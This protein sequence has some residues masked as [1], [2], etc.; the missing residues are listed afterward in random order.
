MKKL[1]LILL[2]L[3]SINVFSQWRS[4]FRLTNDPSNS[5]TSF[6]NAHCIAS[7]GKIVHVTW[8]DNRDGNYEIYYKRSTNGGINWGADT[9]LSYT[10]YVSYFPS[11]AV[12]GQFIYIVWEEVKN[13][14]VIMYTGSSNG[15]NNWSEPSTVS[16][17]TDSASS[18]SLS[19]CDKYLHLVWEDYSN[20][21]YEIYY[22]NSTDGGISWGSETRLTNNPADSYLPCISANGQF[23]HVVWSDLRTGYSTIYYKHSTNGGLSWSED[24]KL[25]NN[26]NSHS[27]T[28]SISMY[29]NLT[30]VVWY[31]NRD[32][33]YEI[34][35]TQSTNGGTN[36]SADTRLTNNSAISRYPSVAI[37]GQTV[38]VVWEDYRDAGGYS[39]IFYKSST[40][41]GLNW[42]DELRLVN[43][44]IPYTGS[45]HPSISASHDS[46]YVI[47][48]DN[49]DGNY[50]VYF[51]YNPDVSIAVQNISTEI[52][53][54]Y[55]LTQNY[56][57]PFNPSTNVK[58]SIVNA[59]D[60]KLVVYDVQGR[61]VQTL[62]NESLKPGTY[63]VSF[64]GSSLTSG[65][66]FYRLITD[67]FTETKK[68]LLLK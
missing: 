3:I 22:K 25:S 36:W 59:G 66:Y 14:H 33:N 13:G 4:D 67:G 38:N 55:S 19:A 28:P 63:E 12:A 9:R 39:R 29:G 62:V 35:Y 16:N 37:S 65:V 11:I 64:D 44:N 10:N 30:G 60:V 56:P 21:G 23:L 47:W 34:Y 8:Y 57:N 20:S 51:K 24:I 53:K 46:V 18:P 49:R 54:E 58:F 26:I 68:M 17:I 1:F 32:G 31:D 6:N 41:G 43:N 45:Y 27:Y 61:E 52:P 15:G 7:D 42:G 5:Y 40:N 50:E 2:I 48:Y